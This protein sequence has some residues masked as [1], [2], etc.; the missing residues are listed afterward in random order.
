MKCI[1]TGAG[2]SR[3]SRVLFGTWALGWTLRNGALHAAIAGVRNEEQARENA[4]A[5]R[6]RLSETEWNSVSE[7]FAPLRYS[8]KW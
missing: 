1:K 8:G 2:S 6:V 7:A 5:C 3:L 4:G